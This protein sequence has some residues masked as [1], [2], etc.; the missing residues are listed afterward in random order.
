M[1][2]RRIPSFHPE[3]RTDGGFHEDFGFRR[4]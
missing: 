1:Q 3:R 2:D 4:H